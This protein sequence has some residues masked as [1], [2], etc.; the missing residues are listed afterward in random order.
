MA[1]RVIMELIP[2]PDN[3]ENW[4]WDEAYEGRGT[5]QNGHADWK[6]HAG[7]YAWTAK[8]NSGDTIH[9]FSSERAAYLKLEELDAADSTTRRYKVIEV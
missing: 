2:K 7:G 6:S 9:E 8:L 3:V 1:Y 5:S 4:K